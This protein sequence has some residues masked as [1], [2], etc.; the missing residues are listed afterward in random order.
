MATAPKF[1]C[2][3]EMSGIVVNDIILELLSP[4]FD[5]LSDNQKLMGKNN[6][7]QIGWLK[8]LPRK[9]DRQLPTKI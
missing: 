1:N 5:I 8:N 6:R 7:N 2:S 9:T 4:Q 3:G